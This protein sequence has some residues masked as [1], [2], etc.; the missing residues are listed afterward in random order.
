M[1]RR[2]FVKTILQGVAAAAVAS[3][4]DPERLLWKPGA[5]TIFLPAPTPVE[6]VEPVKLFTSQDA[7]RLE[8][9]SLRRLTAEEAGQPGRYRIDLN[10]SAY[11]H[12]M[13]NGGVFSGFSLVT[14]DGRPLRSAEFHRL[15]ETAQGEVLDVEA[16]HQMKYLG[17]KLSEEE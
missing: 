2:D 10:E 13:R 5:K 7:V 11:A 4:L 3:D 15:M 12:D 14:V 6:V 17:I 9:R 8:R 16:Q 1:N